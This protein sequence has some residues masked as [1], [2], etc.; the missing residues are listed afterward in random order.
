MLLKIG[1]GVSNHRDKN[2]RSCCQVQ[3]VQAYQDITVPKG[4]TAFAYLSSNPL[5][6][7]TVSACV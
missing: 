3:H 5:S 1:L 7:H 4:S 2:F 6:N